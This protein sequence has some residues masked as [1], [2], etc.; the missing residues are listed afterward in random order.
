MKNNIVSSCGYKYLV[1]ISKDDLSDLDSWKKKVGITKDTY[2]V[3]ISIDDTTTEEFFDYDLKLKL[4]CPPGYGMPYFLKDIYWLPN[5]HIVILVR[6]LFD[7]CSNRCLK[8]GNAMFLDGILY[9][10]DMF[11][12]KYGENDGKKLEIYATD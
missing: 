12:K 10:R 11:S 6:G 8:V 1:K 4:H 7:L 2:F 3:D 5:K 9:K